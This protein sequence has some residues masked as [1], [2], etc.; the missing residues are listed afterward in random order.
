MLNS[1]NWQ[2]RTHPRGS[3]EVSIA[4]IHCVVVFNSCWSKASSCHVQNVSNMRPHRNGATTTTVL[5]GFFPLLQKS[6]NLRR[7]DSKGAR[8]ATAYGL[9]TISFPLV[10]AIGTSGCLVFTFLFKKKKRKYPRLFDFVYLSVFDNR[11][12]QLS[13][14]SEYDPI[15]LLPDNL[16]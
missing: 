3:I 2:P 8:A 6:T 7:W 16:Q 10:R 12:I 1:R 5:A 13:G 14:A 4:R 15:K 11:I 9:Q